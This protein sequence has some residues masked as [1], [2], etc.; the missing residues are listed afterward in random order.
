MRSETVDFTKGQKV[1]HWLMAL[2]ILVD[3]TVAQQFGGDMELADRLQTRE[4][5]AAIGTIILTLFVI[6]IVL[7]LR[8]GAPAFGTLMSAWQKVLASLTHGGFYLLVAV[9]LVT[10]ALSAGNAPEALSLF[11]QVDITFADNASEDQF[12]QVRSYHETATKLLIGLIIL[13]VAA[14]LFHVFVL[15]DGRVK[16][17]LKFWSRELSDS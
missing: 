16:R 2:L 6:R 13:H 10:G 15:K 1:V 4:G 12:Q 11:G 8:N 5:H 9:V 17:M 14:A 3:L 7:R